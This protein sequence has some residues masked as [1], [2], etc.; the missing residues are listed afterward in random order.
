ML[1][2][3]SAF[4]TWALSNGRVLPR[5]PRRRVEAGGFAGLLRRPGARAAVAHWWNRVLEQ[6]HG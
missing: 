2:E 3:T 5:I 4:L 6:L 1:A